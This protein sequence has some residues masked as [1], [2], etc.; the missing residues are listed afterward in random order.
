MLVKPLAGFW[1]DWIVCKRVVR[2]L[3]RFA[4]PLEVLPEEDALLP[5]LW[6]AM[7]VTRFWKS[8]CRVLT[9]PL[10]VPLVEERL[11]IKLSNPLSRLL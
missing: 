3:C 2:K 11:P 8:D 6:P 1:F 4:L 9:A 5:E 7:A 10:V